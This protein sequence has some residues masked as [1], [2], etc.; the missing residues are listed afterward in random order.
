MALR[1]MP[2]NFAGC[3]KKNIY[4]YT[5]IYI[6]RYILVTTLRFLYIGHIQGNFPSPP[7][8][9]CPTDSSPCMGRVEGGICR[10]S[11]IATRTLLWNSTQED[12]LHRRERI[13]YKRDSSRHLRGGGG[14]GGREGGSLKLMTFLYVRRGSSCWILLPAFSGQPWRPP[15]RLFIPP[16]QIGTGFGL[17]GL[18]LGGLGFALK[19]PRKPLRPGIIVAASYRG[20][21]C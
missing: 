18:G 2:G 3:L 1:K 6:Y 5:Y 12:A 20:V 10:H 8:R 11:H 7:C 14:E 9:V 13:L 17:R 19:W 16:A 21:A 15:A 4:I